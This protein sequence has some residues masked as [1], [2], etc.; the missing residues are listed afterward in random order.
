ILTSG[1]HL[2][3]CGTPVGIFCLVP[4]LI[5]PIAA[6]HLLS[7]SPPLSSL[8]HRDVSLPPGLRKSARSSPDHPL[9]PLS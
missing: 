4:W 1:W 5:R 8:N 7:S 9:L 3:I 6:G 2:S